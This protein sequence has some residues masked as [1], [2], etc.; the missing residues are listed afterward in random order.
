MSAIIIRL[1]FTWEKKMWAK[2]KKWAANAAIWLFFI[3][4]IVFTLL[5]I[6]ADIKRQFSVFFG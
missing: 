5:W 2:F 4:L 3:S 6:A 1:L